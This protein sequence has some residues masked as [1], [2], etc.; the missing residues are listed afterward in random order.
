MRRSLVE[1]DVLSK[2]Q[3]IQGRAQLTHCVRKNGNTH[4]DRRSA[5]WVARWALSHVATWTPGAV[6]Y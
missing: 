2:T 5:F 4:L 3:V 1:T 6:E